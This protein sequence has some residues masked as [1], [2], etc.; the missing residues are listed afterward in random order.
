[1]EH[2]HYETIELA[3]TM[4]GDLLATLEDKYTDYLDQLARG[5]DPQI[6]PVTLTHLQAER[7]MR[8]LWRLQELAAERDTT[9]IRKVRSIATDAIELLED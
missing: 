9:T 6:E 3:G 1:M 8:I 7:I 4:M 5:E 2:N